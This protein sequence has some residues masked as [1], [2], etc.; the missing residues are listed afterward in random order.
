MD[1]KTACSRCHVRSAIYRRYR[2]DKRYW[3]NHDVPFETRIPPLDQKA[4]DWEE[5]DP[6]DADDSPGFGLEDY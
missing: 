6:R 4:L 5:F 2:P 3:K 1:F